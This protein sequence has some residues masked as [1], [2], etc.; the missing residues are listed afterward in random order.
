MVSHE[1]RRFFTLLG[2]ILNLFKQW[3]KL[4]PIQRGLVF[5]SLSKYSKTVNPPKVRFCGKHVFW[6]LK[7]LE[8]IPN[9]AKSCLITMLTYVRR[10][11][12]G[13]ILANNSNFCLFFKIRD[14]C[15]LSPRNPLLSEQKSH[16]HRHFA[17]KQT[18]IDINSTTKKQGPKQNSR[19]KNIK[20]Q[21]KNWVNMTPPWLFQG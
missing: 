9:L 20:L 16:S 4:K 12:R 13:K 1:K 21:T 17:L 5:L 18:Y 15:Q 10:I 6:S 7:M 14:F 2:S 8:I 11:L 19:K 3:T